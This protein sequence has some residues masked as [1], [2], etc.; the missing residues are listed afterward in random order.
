MQTWSRARAL[1][2]IG[3]ALAIPQTSRAGALE[4]QWIGGF[5]GAGEWVFVRVSVNAGDEGPVGTI[6][7]P[8]EGEF[9]IPLERLRHDDRRASFEIP[10]HRA[11][12]LFEGRLRD[13]GRLSG[14]VRQ[15]VARGRFELMRLQVLPEQDFKPY[16]GN[17]VFDSGAV[18]LVFSGPMGP[19]YVDYASGRFGQLYPIDDGVFVSGK[20]LY[21]GWPVDQTVRFERRADGTVSDVVW[22]TGEE[23]PRRGVW[24]RFYRAEPVRYPSGAVSL[25][26]TLLVP[27][28]PG[29]HPAVVMIHGSGPTTRRALMPLADALARGGIA[30][31]VP[32]KRGAGAS[33]GNWARAT[34]DDLASDAIAGVEWLLSRPEINHRQIGLHG[35]SLG[36]WVAP[37]AATRSGDVSF[38]IVEAAPG[39]SPIDHERRRVEAQMQADGFTPHVIA[40]ALRFMDLKF[41]VARSGE[42]WERLGSAVEEAHRQGWAS[43]VNPP[44]SLESLQWNWRHVLSYD[45]LPAL[46]RLKVPV[47][48]LYGG[49]DTIVPTAQHLAPFEQALRRAGNPDVTIQVFPRANHH[50]FEAVTGGRGEVARLREF[51]DG[52]FDARVDWLLERVDE[53]PAAAD[54]APVDTSV[55]PGLEG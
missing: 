40:A 43:Y 21:S 46:E 9:G 55:L 39:L 28:S 24:R 4:G 32:D 45:P 33:T 19:A 49:L 16:E 5:E 11:N 30:V 54:A 51:V 3:L 10:G 25:G 31:L 47:L 27:A 20:S 12:L 48:A 37:L 17:Y 7:L 8:A 34:F 23:A 22:Q 29:P 38:I 2:L 50:F 1:V 52:Y 36:G 13:D 41:D 53:S 15:G 44:S 42:G 14:S 26:A 6:D 18:V 35:A